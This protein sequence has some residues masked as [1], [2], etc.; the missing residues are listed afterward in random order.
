[1]VIAALA[2][3]GISRNNSGGKPAEETAAK[4]ES[5]SPE[6]NEAEPAA[7][8]EPAT[9][10]VPEDK[11]D[12]EAPENTET[13]EETGTAKEDGNQSQSTS[14]KG[15]IGNKGNSSGTA[16]EGKEAAASESEGSDVGAAASEGSGL[17]ILE[18]DSVKADA[19]QTVQNQDQSGDEPQEQ[20][21]ETSM[22]RDF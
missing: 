16:T 17:P 9:A 2:V 4:T 1:M 11:K 15:N 20:E 14:G 21:N 6:V 12:Q 19:G 13:P 3:M 10:S 18:L 8:S 7:V 22:M 5:V